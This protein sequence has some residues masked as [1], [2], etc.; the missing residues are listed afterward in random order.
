MEDVRHINKTDPATEQVFCFYRGAVAKFDGEHVANVC[1]QC[2]YWGGLAGGYGVECVY[3]DPSAT[4]VAV[5][6]TKPSAA[7]AEAPEVPEDK[8]SVASQAGIAARDAR[9]EMSP[10]AAE[11]EIPAVEPAPATDEAAA[12]ESTPLAAPEAAPKKKKPVPP[13]FQRKANAVDVITEIAKHLPDKHDQASH[14]H[15]KQQQGRSKGD[16]E[17]TPDD[18]SDHQRERLYAYRERQPSELVRLYRT[19]DRPP[20]GISLGAGQFRVGEQGG[21]LK[22]QLKMSSGKIQTIFWDDGAGRW[23][24][25]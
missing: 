9:I 11:G 23:R 19:P 17:I 25:A 20:S 2:P 21:W 22:G 24:K 8:D 10:P 6:Y 16:R 14:G 12:E 18:L 5:T 4:A 13:Q 1:W 7:A 15:G 3:D